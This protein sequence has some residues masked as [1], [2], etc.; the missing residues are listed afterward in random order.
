MQVAEFAAARGHVP[1]GV[2]AQ[3][4][5]RVAKF[6]RERC[7][8]IVALASP[9]QI[10]HAQSVDQHRD[11]ASWIGERGGQRG[12]VDR[13]RDPALAQLHWNGQRIAGRHQI[14]SEDAVDGR[15]N[16]LTFLR[17]RAIREQR[18]EYAEQ[19]IDAASD[20][21]RDPAH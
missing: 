8:V 16:G 6:A 4:D 5:R 9:L 18:R 19:G 11:L 2:V 17:G 1:A 7:T 12:A 20:Q 14:V 15:Q 10:V 21:A 3:V 13:D